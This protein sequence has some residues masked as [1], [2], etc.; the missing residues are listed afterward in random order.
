MSAKKQG[1]LTA[2]LTA[3][4]LFTG[5]AAAFAAH[6]GGDVTLK[7]AGGNPITNGTT[8]YSPKATC[9]GCH[10]YGSGDKFST[11][12]QG[13]IENDNKVYWQAYQTKS[14]EHGVST[15][16]HSNQGRNEDYN[17]AFRAAVG[18]PFFTSSPGMFGKY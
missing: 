15:G 11:H 9:G 13:V 3:I 5:G 16:R 2:V 18:D 17:N 6:P 7:D 1:L 8:P 14:F 12:V 4:A 10:D